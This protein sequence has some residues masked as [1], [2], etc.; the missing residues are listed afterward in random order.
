M[1]RRL[2]IMRHLNMMRRLIAWATLLL[3]GTA[4]VARAQSP[5]AGAADTTELQFS[6]VEGAGGV[7]LSVAQAGPA[8]APGILF[9]HGLGQSHLAFAAQLHGD[10][11]RHHHLVAFDLRGHGNSGKPWSDAAYL[12][13]SLWAEDVQRVMQATALTRPLIVAW[14]YGTLVIAD[15]IRAHGTEGIAG[16]VM[17]GATGGLVP[18]PKIAPDPAVL[19]KLT[20][21]HRLGENPGL[22]NTLLAS[23]GTVS[24]LTYRA[25]PPEW[26]TLA[27][28]V[29]DLVPPFARGALGKHLYTNNTDLVGRI[30]VPVLLMAGAEDKGDP[31]SLLQTLSDALPEHA[32]IK[33]YP[34]TGHTVFA[35]QPV[36]FNADLETFSKSV[37]IGREP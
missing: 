23:R 36:E 9:I 18:Y 21:L 34:G 7:P 13:G 33:V 31:A 14:S 29:N 35:E 15:Y 22:E 12:D 32:T 24:L 11:A 20:E 4:A 8:D 27:E 16:V 26:T 30:H 6:Y 25:M 17:I 5:T 19:A 37:T 10:L 3:L 1:T 2:D 28:A